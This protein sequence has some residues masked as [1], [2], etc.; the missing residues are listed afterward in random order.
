MPDAGR[1]LLRVTAHGSQAD[2]GADD[3]AGDAII[4]LALRARLVDL[5]LRGSCRAARIPA[6]RIGCLGPGVSGRARGSCDG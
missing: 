3:A 5:L 2:S 1:V 6:A 4:T